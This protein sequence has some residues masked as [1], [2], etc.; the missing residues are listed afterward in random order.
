MFMGALK[1]IIFIRKYGF[2]VLRSSLAKQFNTKAMK[3]FKRL[4]SFLEPTISVTNIDY[5]IN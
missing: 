4:I 3:Y 2:K 5:F 1:K